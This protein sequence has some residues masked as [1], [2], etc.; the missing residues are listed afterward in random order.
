MTIDNKKEWQID[1]FQLAAGAPIP[2]P[3]TE[4]KIRQ[5][6]I[7]EIAII[8]EEKFYSFVSYFKINKQS[9]METVEDIEQKKAISA[10]TEYEVIKLLIDN[11]P[12][13]GFGMQFIL[14]MVIKDIEIVRFTDTFLFLKVKSGQQYIINNESF[15]VIKEIIYRIFALQDNK[16]EYNPANKAAAEIAKKLEERK[17]FLAQGQGKKGQS[18]LADLVSILAVA[19]HCLNIDEILNLTLYQV[20]ELTK[21]FGMYS[22]YQI[23]IQAMMQGAEDVELID[24][25]KK[26]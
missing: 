10:L 7:R 11:E 16:A 3:N 6:K 8:G 1:F 12:E 15:L 21:R 20:F 9:L 13:V 14:Q 17:R 2:V 26:I 5:P 24:W 25:M 23:Q 22:Q 18:I 4:I 19:F